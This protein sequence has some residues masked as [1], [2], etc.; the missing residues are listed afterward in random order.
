MLTL[1]D[2]LLL[3]ICMHTA[4]A[5]PFRRY[6][7]TTSIQQHSSLSR[8]NLAQVHTV[9]SSSDAMSAVAK[10]PS[11]PSQEIARIL[12]NSRVE[13]SS[14]ACESML[15]SSTTGAGNADKGLAN[16]YWRTSSSP[17]VAHKVVPTH[18]SSSSFQ[19]H[20]NET[21]QKPNDGHWGKHGEGRQSSSTTTLTLYT[22]VQPL[23]HPISSD[24]AYA[25][26]EQGASS[27]ILSKTGSSASAPVSSSGAGAETTKKTRH[28]KPA[29]SPAVY[30]TLTLTYSTT[31]DTT[32]GL[33]TLTL[34]HSSKPRKTNHP[35]H[36]RQ[37]QHTKHR[38]TSP[39]HAAPS[40]SFAYPLPKSSPT[41]KD[42]PSSATV[43]P[44]N[45]SKGG[46]WPSFSY[47]PPNPSS[48]SLPAV[49]SQ[50][51]HGHKSSSFISST[52]TTG[53]G[54]ITI[55]PV[56]PDATTI[57]I[58]VTTTTTDAGVTTTVAQDT[59]TVGNGGWWG[60]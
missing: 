40:S 48:D 59:V 34:S 47:S 52:T 14:D 45:T 3:V 42:S 13:G 17:S 12:Q 43:D 50:Q 37:K 4:T 39:T 35:K 22:T 24:S 21:I 57:Y 5:S 26:S 44:V 30:G 6:Q 38:K 36:T 49:V 46:S 16:G 31:S 19:A 51:P 54:G 28:H 15:A 9:A 60:Q 58:T 29:S 32:S 18:G 33:V 56:N 25:S 27:S 20:R 11:Q 2:I 53:I 8:P 1:L 41:N 55:V 7:N 10:R 23:Q